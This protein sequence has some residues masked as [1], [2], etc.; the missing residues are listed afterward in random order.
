MVSVFKVEGVFSFLSFLSLSPSLSSLRGARIL[1]KLRSVEAEKPKA[2]GAQHFDL[3]EGCA[4]S[5]ADGEIGMLKKS[6]KV[7]EAKLRINIATFL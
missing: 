7:M 4:V 6:N 1:E 3:D 2:A 5:A